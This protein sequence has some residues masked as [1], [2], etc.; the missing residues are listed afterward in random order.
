M[1]ADSVRTVKPGNHY[2]PKHNVEYGALEQ[3]GGC[4]G[5]PAAVV[6]EEKLELPDPPKGCISSDQREAWFTKLADA[7]LADAARVKKR[8]AKD[9]HD[10]IAIKGHRET[11]IKA[12][13]AAGELGGRREDF[14]IV[15]ARKKQNQTGVPNPGAPH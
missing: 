4:V 15:E 2:C 11:A 10:E 5:D 13:R 7:A 14:E 6:T 8:K 3:C 9:W 1:T 12:M